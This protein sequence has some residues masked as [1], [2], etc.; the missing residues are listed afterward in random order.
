MSHLGDEMSVNG[1]EGA[2]LA[3]QSMVD[4]TSVVAVQPSSVA[5]PEDTLIA[6]S[7]PPPMPIAVGAGPS[8]V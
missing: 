2:D 5:E 1:A 7:P 8:R 6:Q 3:S 4:A